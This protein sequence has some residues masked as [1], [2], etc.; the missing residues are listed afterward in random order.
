VLL[1]HLIQAH[2]KVQRVGHE[3]GSALQTRL[4]M[5][6]VGGGASG[7]KPTKCALVLLPP[8]LAGTHA[9][10]RVLQTLQHI[11]VLSQTAHHHSNNL[12]YF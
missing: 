6:T 11:V 8:A 12:C 7:G 9:R 2:S 1:S 4:A 10:E 3:H 5:M